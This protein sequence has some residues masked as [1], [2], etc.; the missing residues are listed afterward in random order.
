MSSQ[1]QTGD[2]AVQACKENEYMQKVWQTAISKD[3]RHTLAYWAC[4]ESDMP[5][6]PPLQAVCRDG[7]LYS[8]ENGGNQVKTPPLVPPQVQ[9]NVWWK[10]G[11]IQGQK[12]PPGTGPRRWF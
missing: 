10:I 2:K 4:L 6:D 9:D 12:F 3:N 1:T 5:K 11:Y 7:F 8:N